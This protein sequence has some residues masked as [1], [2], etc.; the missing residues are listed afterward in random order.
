MP[1][2]ILEKIG[3]ALIGG[4]VSCL[5]PP[6]CRLCQAPLF[7]HASPYLCQACAAGVEWIGEGACRKCGFPAGPGARL[8]QGCSRCRRLDLGLTAVAATTRYRHGARSLVLALKFRG[9]TSIARP[10]ASLMAERFRNFGFGAIDWIV[11]A[12]L[13]P[14]RRRARGFDQSS[15]LGRHLAGEID[16]LLR[17]DLLR[18]VRHTR[19]QSSLTRFGRLEN[20]RGAF[21]A[22]PGIA[23]GRILLV[24]DVMTTGATLR[25]CARACR[26]A[27]ATRVYALVFAR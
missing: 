6:R 18:R 16:I 21:T 17:E 7:D 24:D 1:V 20:A 9:E 27:G 23:G 13:H 3:H 15:L 2:A 26:E 19:P 11:P 25:D 8:G 4:I 5:S 12:S 22:S 10:M 14:E